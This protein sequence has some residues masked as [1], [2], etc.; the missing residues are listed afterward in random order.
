MD[1][2]AIKKFATWAR[3]ELI[4]RV[5]QKGVEYSITEESEQWTVGSEEW[6]ADL[7]LIHI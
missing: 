2:N 3:K 6:A 5:S 7:S 1:K 4:A